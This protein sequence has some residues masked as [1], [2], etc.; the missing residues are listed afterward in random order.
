LCGLRTKNTE[1][2]IVHIN[3][4]LQKFIAAAVQKESCANIKKKKEAK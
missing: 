3:E 1:F 4:E 2:S